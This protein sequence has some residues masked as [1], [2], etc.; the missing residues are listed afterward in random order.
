MAS[1]NY[2]K[3]LEQRN[4]GNFTAGTSVVRAMLVKNTYVYSESHDFVSD[5]VAHEVSGGSYTREDLTGVTQ[6]RDTINN[7]VI[8]DA[9]NI[10]FTGVPDQGDDTVG[11]VVYFVFVTNDA[12]SY[13]VN[14]Q[15]ATNIAGNGSDILVTIPATGIHADNYSVG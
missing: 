6:T 5:V 11:G 1:A 8:I 9:D 7:R 3:F 15:D 14:F 12:D 4:L 2:P 13:L 10:T